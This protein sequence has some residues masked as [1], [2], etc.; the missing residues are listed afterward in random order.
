[1]PSLHPLLFFRVKNIFLYETIKEVC[2]MAIISCV[3]ICILIG[4]GLLKMVEKTDEYAKKHKSKH[5]K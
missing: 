3:G 4:S 1:M 2:I 5:N